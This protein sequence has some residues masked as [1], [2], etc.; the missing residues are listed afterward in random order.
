MLLA[1]DV[2]A[3]WREDLEFIILEDSIIDKTFG[4]KLRKLN[5]RSR[6]IGSEK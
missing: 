5:D 6:W 1:Y 3:S 2:K 4:A